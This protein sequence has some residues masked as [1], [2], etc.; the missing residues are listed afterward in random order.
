MEKPTKKGTN[1]KKKRLLFQ[2]LLKKQKN[3]K[4]LKLK[5]KVEKNTIN[6]KSN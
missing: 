4:K 1:Q 3:T 5:K 2:N 6:D